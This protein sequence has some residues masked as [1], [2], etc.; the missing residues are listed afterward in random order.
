MPRFFF[1]FAVSFFLN[2]LYNGACFPVY[3]QKEIER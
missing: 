1:V 3:Y 2:F